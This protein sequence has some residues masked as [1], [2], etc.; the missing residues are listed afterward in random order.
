MM[1]NMKVKK[2][3]LVS[4]VLVAI[5]T[6]VVAAVGV[7]AM[8]IM[9]ANETDMY[10][11]GLNSDYA[12]DM[13]GILQRERVIYR[14]AIIAMTIDPA[15]AQEEIDKIALR[16]MELQ[17][18]ITYLDGSLRS[19]TG[20]QH[21]SDIKA[22]FDAFVTDRQALFDT[23]A[24][25]DQ[26]AA[27]SML[28]ATE[29]NFD[30]TLDSVHALANYTLELSHETELADSSLS[31]ILIIVVFILGIGSVVLSIYFAFYIS[32]L[33]ANP[34]NKLVDAANKIATGDV[35]IHTDIDSKDELGEL[36]AA[37]D[38]MAEGIQQ[39]AAAVE[40]VSKG[41][42]SVDLAV[43]SEKDTMNKAVNRLVDNMNDAMR[44][45]SETS[46]QV[47]AGSSQVADGAQALATGSTQQAA[48]IEEFS[49]TINELSTQAEENTQLADSTLADTNQA[50][51][52]MQ[53]SIEHMG[54]L[55]QAMGKIDDSSQKIAKVIKVIEDIAFQTNILAL[56][57]AVEAARAGEHGKGFAVVA[58]EVRNLAS[59]SAEAAKETADLIQNSVDNV[60]DG[61]R[62]AEETSESLAK[63]GEISQKNAEAMVKLSKSSQH[64][65]ESVTQ[66]NEG[67]GQI[68]SVIQA[69]SAT[70][71]QSAAASEEM[72]AQSAVLNK[73]VM[74]FKLKDDMQ[75]QGEIAPPQLPSYKK[76]DN[77]DDIIF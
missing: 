46:N 50:G 35:E 59:K 65:T 48:T 14:D 11:Q 6:A 56:N 64:Q 18:V 9:S 26:E 36:A 33:I 5:F 76:S 32:K 27:V 67:I 68:S 73:I 54:Q 15:R 13:V 7:T 57:A 58:D 53:I 31:K 71:E 29:I 25:G 44:E 41:D 51:E 77:K 1:K 4:F 22:S 39:Q 24:A 2:K 10:Q 49:A 28:D 55:T 63:V 69:N 72:S 16:D 62:I 34:V 42:F 17:D 20:K 8:S 19:E 23:I 66:I 70:A 21:L 52:L 74:R 43:R 45:L 37:F 47:A 61:N 30:K 38:K 40:E 12:N 60:Q 75:A 3:L